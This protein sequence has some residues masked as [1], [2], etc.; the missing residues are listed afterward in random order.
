MPNP[1]MWLHNLLW[2]C[3]NW[4]NSCLSNRFGLRMRVHC[5]DS[6]R[7]PFSFPEPHPS[8]QSATTGSAYSLFTYTLNS[9]HT[10]HL[11]IAFRSHSTNQWARKDKSTPV[12]F[13]PVKSS[14][15]HQNLND[16]KIQRN[17]LQI[18]VRQFII[19]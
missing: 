13:L 4:F 8:R 9:M 16:E 19:I 15:I 11:A 10:L 2:N 1:N 12:W 6:L 5:E 14:F 3:I 18:I 17:I 7:F